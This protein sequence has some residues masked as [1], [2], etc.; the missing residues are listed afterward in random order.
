[1]Q[2][3]VVDTTSANMLYYAN[4]VLYKVQKYAPSMLSLRN[5]LMVAVRCNPEILIFIE[6]TKLNS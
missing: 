5:I 1:M 3:G 6:E 4:Q 2:L